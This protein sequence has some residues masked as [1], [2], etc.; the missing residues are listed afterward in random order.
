MKLDLNN[1][2]IESLNDEHG[3]NIIKW[4]KKQGIETNLDGSTRQAYGLYN[5]EFYHYPSDFIRKGKVKVITL[6][7]PLM[8]YCIK[9]SYDEVRPIYESIGVNF[10]MID[11][12][13]K[14]SSFF[15]IEDN[16]INAYIAEK[17]VRKI[18]ITPNQAKQMIE[19]F[20]APEHKA[21]A[22]VKED[23]P[24][25]PYLAKVW[26][27]DYDDANIAIVVGKIEV[28]KPKYP[29]LVVIDEDANSFIDGKTYQTSRFKNAEPI[30]CD[31]E[32]ITN[33]LKEIDST[34]V[35]NADTIKSL[36]ITNNK[37]YDYKEE[38]NKIKELLELMNKAK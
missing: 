35:S 3:A 14:G 31:L 26:D 18:V 27:D 2:V 4:W 37:L 34:L 10:N 13:D 16:E 22:E 36:R 12:E 29:I 6:P 7:N 24:T 19:E 20:Y 17:Y 1:T 23:K 33:K 11:E 25:Y 38:V 21:E 30:D 28:G 15:F 8:N 9:G 32:S 5:D